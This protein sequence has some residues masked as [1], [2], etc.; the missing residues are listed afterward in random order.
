MI[1]FGCKK[2][3]I[4]NSIP[5]SLVLFI[6]ILERYL[7]CLYFLS[8]FLSFSN[9]IVQLITLYFHPFKGKIN[10][11]F[12]FGL[13]VTAKVVWFRFLNCYYYTIWWLN[14]FLSFVWYHW[15]CVAVTV[16]IRVSNSTKFNQP[17]KKEPILNNYFIRGKHKKKPQFNDDWWWKMWTLKLWSSGQ[18]FLFMEI[19]GNSLKAFSMV[20][21]VDVK[22]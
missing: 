15:L 14:L 12:G 19:N 8:F 20:I 17:T 7:C 6:F 5:T 11:P 21:I 13:F 1:F 4:S 2:K 10:W 9:L 3:V 16:A 22:W 18:L